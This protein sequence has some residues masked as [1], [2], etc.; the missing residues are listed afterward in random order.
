MNF[1][2]K[3]NY[4][5]VFDNKKGIYIKYSNIH[6]TVIID[7]GKIEVCHSV[8]TYI[9]M[10]IVP[11]QESGEN[12]LNLTLQHVEFFINIKT[13]RKITHKKKPLGELQNYGI[14]DKASY[15]KWC[16]VNHP[17]KVPSERKADATELFQHISVLCAS[18]K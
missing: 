11:Y 4:K 18:M 12:P 8:D 5:Y 16:I 10:Y 14:I 3:E 1:S 7:F 13:K 15:K 2:S 17:D 6:D 9:D